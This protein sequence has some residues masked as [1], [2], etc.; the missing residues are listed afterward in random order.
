MLVERTLEIYNLNDKKDRG[1]Y[2]GSGIYGLIYNKNIIYVGQST[3]I[4]KRLTSH[5]AP[6]KVEYIESLIRKEQ[7]SCNRE[8]SLAMYRFI[9]DHR[10]DIGFVILKKCSIEDLN[11]QEKKYITMFKPMYN[12]AG[13][14]KEIKEF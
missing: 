11:K 2:N 4:H 10:D 12:Y 1:V 3:N 5:N 7:G 6:G 14:D 8:K 9:R 13:V